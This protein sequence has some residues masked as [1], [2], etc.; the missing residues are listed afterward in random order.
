MMFQVR[1]VSSFDFT[2]PGY[3][4]LFARSEATAFQHPIWL[5][6]LYARLA[7]PFGA[8][9]LVVLVTENGR[10]ALVLPLLRRRRGGL[11]VVE[12]AD[13]GVSDYA[14]PVCSAEDFERICAD[15]TALGSIAQALRPYDL[16]RVPKVRSD[17]LDLSRLLPRSLKQQMTGHAHAA[18]LN[19]PFQTWRQ[20][21]MPPC[22]CR[23]LDRKRKKLSRRGPY[24]IVRITEAGAI[25]ATFAASLELRRPRFLA[26]GTPDV[27]ED[28]AAMSFYVEVAAAGASDGW[29]RTYAMTFGGETVATLFALHHRRRLLVLL[30][31]FDERL[32]KL[33]VGSLLFE[34]VIA[35]CIR[36][37][38]EVFD[39]TIGDEGYK[40]AFGTEQ[41]GL[42]AVLKP[43]SIV[44]QVAHLMLSTTW[45]T[46]IVKG[47]ARS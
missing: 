25:A 10:L 42:G 6:R 16:L 13:L 30:S 44:G 21:N 47:L 2:A 38:D 20:A 3:S 46:N 43:G 33:S 14:A 35:D 19:G 36:E 11:R 9:P 18:R 12:F 7:P 27:L 1:A 32:R 22:Y 39:L 17:G 5:D 26:R 41:T 8:T 40:K 29:A 15:R 45:T 24:R 28:S 4:A 23:E 34:D 31:A 37:G